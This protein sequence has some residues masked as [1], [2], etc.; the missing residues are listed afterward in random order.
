MLKKKLI[1]VGEQRLVEHMVIK[2]ILNEINFIKLILI[3]AEGIPTYL[4]CIIMFFYQ[5]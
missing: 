3:E 1:Y 5:N 4:S 2:F